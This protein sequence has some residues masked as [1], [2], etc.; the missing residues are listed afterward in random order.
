MKIFKAFLLTGIVFLTSV[1]MANAASLIDVDFEDVDLTSNPVIL[2]NYA[3]LAWTNLAVSNAA[4]LHYGVT[5]D[6]AAYS[7]NRPNF[8]SLY[9]PVTFSFKEMEFTPIEKSGV[10]LDITGTR[11]LEDNT[12]EKFYLHLTNLRLDNTY[13]INADTYSD[14]NFDDINKLEIRATYLKNQSGYITQCNTNYIIDN[15]KYVD[16]PAA[17]NPEPSSLILGIIG[18]GGI[19]GVKRKK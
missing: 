15:F 11:Y 9:S 12:T 2:T 5:G 4:T 1:H 13:T 16:P 17:P 19:F 10:I 18:L 3:G 6:K 7:Y 14:F 8:T